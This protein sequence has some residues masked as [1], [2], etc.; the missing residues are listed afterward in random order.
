MFD[1]QLPTFSVIDGSDHKATFTALVTTPCG[2]QFEVT[3]CRRLGNSIFGKLPNSDE[4]TELLVDGI[5]I[6]RNLEED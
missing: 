5:A 4:E 3:D 2:K 1:A 6:T